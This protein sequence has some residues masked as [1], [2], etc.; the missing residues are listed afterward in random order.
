MAE[1]YAT[2]RVWDGCSAPGNLEFN[3]RLRGQRVSTISIDR[4]ELLAVCAEIE[5]ADVDG[6]S[7]WPKRIRR[8]IGEE[9]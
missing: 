4:D 2:Y 9:R 7:D 3:G 6:F 1:K 5:D 8:A